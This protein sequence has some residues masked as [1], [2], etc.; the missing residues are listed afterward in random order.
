MNILKKIESTAINEGILS[1]PKKEYKL[2]GLLYAAS[3]NFNAN[4]NF[5]TILTRED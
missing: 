3:T 1:P 2:E 5:V 4:N